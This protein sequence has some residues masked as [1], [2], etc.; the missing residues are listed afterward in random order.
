[1]TPY[2]YKTSQQ[3]REK[4]ENLSSLEVEAQF[5]VLTYKKL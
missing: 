1:M 5:C 4:L 3:D 2:C